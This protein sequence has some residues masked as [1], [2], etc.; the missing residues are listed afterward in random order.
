VNLLEG[1]VKV[2]VIIAAGIL[3]LGLVTNATGTATVLNSFWSGINSA[4]GMETAAAG[5]GKME[6]P[7]VYR[8]GR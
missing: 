3:I 6:Q 5:K 1:L 8:G 7:P 2:L 4:F